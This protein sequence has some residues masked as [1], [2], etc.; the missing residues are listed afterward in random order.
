MIESPWR[1]IERGIHQRQS[2]AESRL[3]E[4]L[5][6]TQSEIESLEKRVEALETERISNIV[7]RDFQYIS[8]NTVP[9][10]QHLLVVSCFC[11]SVAV[12]VASFLYYI[13]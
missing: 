11:A 8:M 4:I 10:R 9:K 2:D 7:D 3:K 5:R 13:L 1:K 12:F 6:T